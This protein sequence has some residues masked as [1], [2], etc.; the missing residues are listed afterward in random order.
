MVALFIVEATESNRS[1]YFSGLRIT[2]FFNLFYWYEQ[3]E[4]VPNVKEE[5]NTIIIAIPFEA[6]SH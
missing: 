1:I 2:F 6:K 4:N 3:G 5:A